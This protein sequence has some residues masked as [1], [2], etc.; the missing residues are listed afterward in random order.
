MTISAHDHGTQAL[1]GVV[2]AAD[3]ALRQ[4]VKDLASHPEPAI[5]AISDQTTLLS[6]ALASLAK[7]IGDAPPPD[8]AREVQVTVRIGDVTELLR[9]LHLAA[10]QGCCAHCGGVIDKPD[11]EVGSSDQ[12]TED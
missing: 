10:G 5:K 7:K 6:K 4:A 11:D 9:R 8:R 12:T 3:A 1:A 2:R